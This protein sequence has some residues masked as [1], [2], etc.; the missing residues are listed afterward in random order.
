EKTHHNNTFFVVISNL[1]QCSNRMW[2]LIFFLPPAYR[3][4]L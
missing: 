1:C 2:T 3:A 4:D